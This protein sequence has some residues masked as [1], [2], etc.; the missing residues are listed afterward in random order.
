MDPFEKYDM[1]FNG[2]G[3]SRVMTTSPGKWSGQDN[4][5]TAALFSFALA[6]FD[7]SIMKYPSIKRSPGGASNDLIPNLQHPENPVPA[8]DPAH[9]PTSVGGGG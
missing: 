9:L 6:E 2:A 4:G 3:P 7:K 8:L 1:I 5:W